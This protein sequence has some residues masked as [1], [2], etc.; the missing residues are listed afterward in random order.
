MHGARSHTAT[1]RIH[2]PVH[3]PPTPLPPGGTGWLLDDG[4]ILVAAVIAVGKRPVPS[5]TRK[6]SRP[7][8]MV[9]RGRPRGRVG[10]RRTI[11]H[12]RGPTPDM[13]PGLFFVCRRPYCRRKRKKHKGP[14][15]S[16]RYKAPRC[17][18]PY[19]GG[20]EERECY[21]S[22]SSNTSSS[23]MSS[24]SEK[25]PSKSTA[26]RASAFSTPHSISRSTRTEGWRSKITARVRRSS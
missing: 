21:S 19:A 3:E 24:S 23:S 15:T 20:A 7:A 16:T 1:A 17:V 11:L 10:H 8:P 13:V 26:R 18:T 2:Y 4:S 5:R 9:L 22:S 25:S 12:K 6:L 14:C